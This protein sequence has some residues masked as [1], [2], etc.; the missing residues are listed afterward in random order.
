MHAIESGSMQLAYLIHQFIELPGATL[1]E[2]ELCGQTTLWA[3]HDEFHTATGHSSAWV[4]VQS[5]HRAFIMDH[6]GTNL[7]Q[8]GTSR[9]DLVSLCLLALHTHSDARTMSCN[10][11]H[12]K[13]RSREWHYVLSLGGYLAAVLWRPWYRSVSVAEFGVLEHRE[14]SYLG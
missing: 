8:A 11:P 7:G 13:T 5:R 12:P 10:L 1:W 2:G 3:C 14:L 9:E 4:H 6:Q